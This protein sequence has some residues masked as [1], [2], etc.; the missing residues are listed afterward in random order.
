[1]LFMNVT[2]ASGTPGF[3]GTGGTNPNSALG[4]PGANGSTAANLQ[5][6]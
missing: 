6:N 5:I 3:G 4:G 2:C 1:V